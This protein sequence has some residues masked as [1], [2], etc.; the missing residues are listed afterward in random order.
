[1]YLGIGGR[2]R[3]KGQEKK[4]GTQGVG[5]AWAKAKIGKY[6]YA[7]SPRS[8]IR[9]CPYSVPLGG[10]GIQIGE[11]HGEAHL[12][13]NSSYSSRVLSVENCLPLFFWAIPGENPALVMGR[14]RR[15]VV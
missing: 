11:G 3:G 15:L 7:P 13:L 10:S 12:T 1:M 6:L 8:D 14:R 9:W 2:E 4:R 5:L